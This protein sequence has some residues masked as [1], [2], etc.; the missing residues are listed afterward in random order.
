LFRDSGGNARSY[1]STVRTNRGP[2]AFQ[3]LLVG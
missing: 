1:F 3:N 2:C